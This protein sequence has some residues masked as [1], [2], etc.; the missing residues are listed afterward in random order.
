MFIRVVKP[1]KNACRGVL[2]ERPVMN[3]HRQNPKVLKFLFNYYELAHRQ[4][5]LFLANS[6]FAPKFLAP[7]QPLINESS[8][9]TCAY[10][11]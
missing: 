3:V 7:I 2:R 9:R 5:V 8:T 6:P 11:F 1:D 10:F 4:F